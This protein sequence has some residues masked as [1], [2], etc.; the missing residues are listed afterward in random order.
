M[1][2]NYFK[3]PGGTTFFISQPLN[4]FHRITSWN[5]QKNY[6]SLKTYLAAILLNLAKNQL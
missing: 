1:M 6:F 5:Q 2:E 4:S 3:E